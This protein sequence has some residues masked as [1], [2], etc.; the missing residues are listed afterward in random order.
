MQ[1]RR[2]AGVF[3]TMA[4][5][6]RDLLRWLQHRADQPTAA[7]LDSRTL[8]STPESGQRAGYDRHKRS[9]GS[10]VPLAVDTLG[11][12]LALTITPANAQDRARTEVPLA[13][14]RAAD[15]RDP[16]PGYR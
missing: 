3:A 6:L 8:R 14:R 10:K 11:H 5:D 16:R 13:G 7:I 9:N 4:H 12:L 15:R 1:R 2:I